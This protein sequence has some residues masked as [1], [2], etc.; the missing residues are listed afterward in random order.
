VRAALGFEHPY[1]LEIFAYVVSAGAA[2][3]AWLR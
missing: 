3:F 1:Q 2:W